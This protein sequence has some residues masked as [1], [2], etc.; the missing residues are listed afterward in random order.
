MI[1]LEKKQKEVDILKIKLAICKSEEKETLQN[2]L[3]IKEREVTTLQGL[4]DGLEQRNALLKTMLEKAKNTCDQGGTNDLS[5]IMKPSIEEEIRLEMVCDALKTELEKI[6]REYDSV[7]GIET[8]R[9]QEDASGRMGSWYANENVSFS[10]SERQILVKRL[11]EC[12]GASESSTFWTYFAAVFTEMMGF[13]D[14]C[15]AI[16][17]ER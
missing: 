2:R 4:K 5:N 9:S 6:K 8:Y 16:A 17:R 12:K 3:D 1:D 14:R 15:I 11:E 10:A 13:V 7:H